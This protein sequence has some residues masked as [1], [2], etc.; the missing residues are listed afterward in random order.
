MD[1]AHRTDNLI[2]TSA[3]EVP[4][5]CSLSA[6]DLGDREAEWRALLDRSLVSRERIPSGVRIAVHPSAAGELKRLIDL[7]RTC[8]AWMQFKFDAPEVVAITASAEGVNVLEA[9]FLDRETPGPTTPRSLSQ[10]APPTF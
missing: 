8:C 6:A 10:P 1:R 5:A 7:E 4:I 2:K 3:D 9:M